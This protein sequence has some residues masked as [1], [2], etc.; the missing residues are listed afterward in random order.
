M[1]R[2]E[3]EKEHYLCL[4]LPL[5]RTHFFFLSCVPVNHWSSSFLL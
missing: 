2:F 3:I 4:L 1:S 5:S